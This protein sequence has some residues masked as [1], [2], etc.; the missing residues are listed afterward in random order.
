MGLLQT[1]L[2]RIRAAGGELAE[3]AQS[4]ESTREVWELYLD[5]V[6]NRTVRLNLQATIATLAM[7]LIAVP[8]SLAGM[9]LTHGF[10]EASPSIFWGLTGGL[11]CVSS[12]TWLAFMRT[13][14]S[15]G[16][17]AAKR[18]DD[19]RALRFV[20]NRMDDL[21][22]VMRAKGTGAG[23]GEGD[24]GDGYGG[25]VRSKDDLLRAIS[26]CAGGAK[27]DGLIS[28]AK[29]LDPAA[30]DLIFKVFDRDGDGRIDPSKEWVI[31]PW[32][33]KRADDH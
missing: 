30:M 4:V 12:T 28:Q 33:I 16:G 10:E 9:N 2:W 22:D 21:D 17:A 18:A 23:D 29:T 32:P 31:R 25:D 14:W 13:Y 3:I 27:R 6:R 11:A 26:S 20:L 15:P 7:T 5:G 1:H 19:L 24:E 8:A